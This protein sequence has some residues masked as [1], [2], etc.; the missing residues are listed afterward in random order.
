MIVRFTSFQFH[1]NS[2]SSPLLGEKRRNNLLRGANNF[3]PPF[4]NR[5][6][7]QNPISSSSSSSITFVRVRFHNT[8]TRLR[9]SLDTL[10]RT[11]FPFSVSTANSTRGRVRWRRTLAKINKFKRARGINNNESR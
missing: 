2:S 8:T 11:M 4:Y 7:K 6:S 1:T 10:E 9:R 5:T 3:P